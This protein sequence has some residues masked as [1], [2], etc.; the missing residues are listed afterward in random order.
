MK[1]AKQLLRT[2]SIRN[3]HNNHLSTA[4]KARTTT[5]LVIC[6]RTGAIHLVAINAMARRSEAGRGLE[7]LARERVVID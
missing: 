6:T 5:N 2:P 1:R 4:V 7:R 3:K